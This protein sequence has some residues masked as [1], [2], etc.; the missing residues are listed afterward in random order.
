MN[1]ADE[2]KLFPKPSNKQG[3]DDKNDPGQIVNKMEVKSNEQYGMK[4]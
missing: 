2:T 1:A 3:G 4:K